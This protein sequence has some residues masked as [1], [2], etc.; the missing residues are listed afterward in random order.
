MKNHSSAT[1]YPEAIDAYIE[2]E[3]QEKA[4]LGPFSHTPHGSYHCSLLLT[5]PKGEGKR[6]VIVDLSY[7]Q[8]EAVNGVPD[9]DSYEGIPFTLQLPT[10]DH[11]LS[12]IVTMKNPYLIKADIAHAFRNV[13]IDPHDVIKCG[14]SHNEQF[15]IAKNLVFGVVNGT[16]FFQR[17]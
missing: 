15:Y 4:L 14:I 7:G 1:Q 3:L 6:R 13:P 11:L 5:R 2:K 12:Q 17:I 16:M 9:R 10:L 8:H